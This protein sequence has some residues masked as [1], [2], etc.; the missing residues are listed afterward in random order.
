MTIACGA[1][2]LPAAANAVS[3]SHK[4]GKGIKL[5]A[6]DGTWLAIRPR[7]MMLFQRDTPEG[8]EAQ[9]ALSIR[10]ARVVFKHGY[11]PLHLNSKLELA[12][13]SR[14]LRFAS[15]GHPRQTPILTWSVSW[16]RFRDARLK[17]GQFKLGYSRQRV[18]SSGNQQMADRTMVQGEFTLDRDIGAELYSKD[19]AGLGM[20]KYVLGAYNGEGRDVYKL[21]GS[22]LLY[23]ARVELLPLGLFDDYSE[24]D[25]KRHP[26]PKVA[27]GVG[28]TQMNDAAKDR[29]VLGSVPADEGTTDHRMMTAD[30]TA[31]W[32]GASLA[33]EG[34]ARSSTRNPG[35]KGDPIKARNGWGATATLG[36]LLP[37]DHDIELT[38]RYGRI[39]PSADSSLTKREEMGGGASWY[40]SGHANKLQLDV[41]R[42]TNADTE[43][44]R[45]RLMLQA[46]L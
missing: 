4:A 41:F 30:L 6:D 11:T 22:P 14:D 1:L 24:A 34:H 7:V 19:L 13:S 46:S 20:L 28:V 9:Q 35:T 39:T 33:I 21:G 37:I 8:G 29:G 36:Y 40:F 5:K 12:M 43:S 44:M 45:V 23:V 42:L 18:I 27:I 25:L 2:V 38:G 15:N 31:K 32:R 3:I 26:S 10:R 17:V 16:D